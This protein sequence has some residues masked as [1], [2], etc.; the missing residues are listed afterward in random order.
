VANLEADQ[1]DINGSKTTTRH[2]APKDDDTEALRKR[3]IAEKTNRINTFGR[4][5]SIG[6]A[7]I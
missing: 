6:I 5:P 2:A 3:V 1:G 7:R 4:N